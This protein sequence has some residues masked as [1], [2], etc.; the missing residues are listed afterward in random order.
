MTPAYPDI[1]F[2]IDDFDSTFDTVVLTKKNHCYCVVLKA[3]DGAAFPCEKVSNDCSTSDNSSV[4]V[5]SSSANKKDTKVYLR[6]LGPSIRCRLTTHPPDGPKPHPPTPDTFLALIHRLIS[7]GLTR[8]AFRAFHDIHTFFQ[9]Q[10][11]PDHFCILLDM[12]C[13]YGYVKLIIIVFNKNK[14]DT[15]F[16]ANAKIYTILIYG[17]CKLRKLD[18]THKFLSEM[19]ER[20]LEPNIVPYNV[21]LNGFFQRVSLHPDERFESTI[22]NAQKMFDEMGSSGIEPDVTSFSIVL[23]GKQKTYNCFFKEF[24]GRKDGDGALRLFKNMKDDGLCLPTSHIY[25]ILIRM[26]LKLDRVGIIK[27]TWN[28]MKD[29]GTGFVKDSVGG[30]LAITL[31]RW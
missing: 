28:D 13:K 30:M 22:R 31:L 21:L 26:F 7:I 23:H 5:Y 8:Q 1:Y 3:H 6:F 17:W 15:R 29:T 14:H 27:E 16:P 11:T 19:K 20:G 12:L 18:T 24:R 9:S 4:E 2:A 25:G 10:L